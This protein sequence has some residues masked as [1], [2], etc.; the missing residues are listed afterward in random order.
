MLTTLCLLI[1]RPQ[2]LGVEILQPCTCQAQHVFTVM[3]VN[4]TTSF[5]SHARVRRQADKLNHIGLNVKA[6]PFILP[7]VRKTGNVKKSIDH[8]GFRAIVSR[9]SPFHT[10]SSISSPLYPCGIGLSP[11]RSDD[12]F[13]MQNGFQVNQPGLFSRLSATD[14]SLHCAP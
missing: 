1:Y 14:N 9:S 3:P 13:E 11:N 4:T 12:T 5:P 2:V 10:L 6:Y 8:C 7:I